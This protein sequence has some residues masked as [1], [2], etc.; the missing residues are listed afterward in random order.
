MTLPACAS[1][2]EVQFEMAIDFDY[3]Q[4]SPVT[5]DVPQ[6]A[7]LDPCAALAS[8]LVPDN[9]D[10]DDLDDGVVNEGVLSGA[11]VTTENTNV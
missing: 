3:V 9:E 5:D 4:P 7:S 8:L 6:G 11:R 10:H 2:S 1:L